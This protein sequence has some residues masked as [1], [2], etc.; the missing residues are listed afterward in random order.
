MESFF[1]VESSG[2]FPDEIFHRL[3]LTVVPSLE[4]TRV[5]QN[6]IKSVW[7]DELILN[8]VFPLLAVGFFSL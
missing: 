4:A 3:D 2:L 8:A 1:E 6:Q 5:M 7:V